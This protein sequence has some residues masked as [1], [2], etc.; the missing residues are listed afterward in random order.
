MGPGYY[1]SEVVHKILRHK[2]VPKKQ[3]WKP[4]N[5]IY[6][7]EIYNKGKIYLRKSPVFLI[8]VVHDL[9]PVMLERQDSPFWNSLSK[10]L[11]LVVLWSFK[12][13]VKR[14][15]IPIYTNFLQINRCTLNTKG[16]L[17]TVFGY[18][19][20]IFCIR[21]L[22]NRQLH[23]QRNNRNTRTRCEIVQIYQ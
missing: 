5:K 6:F 10:D 12:Y 2:L 14:L 23:V 19:T 17:E 13:E 1:F 20:D 9:K 7:F 21:P 4:R 8:L 22:P 15:H 11:H 16:N 18:Y 3:I